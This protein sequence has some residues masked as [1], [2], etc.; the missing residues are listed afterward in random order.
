M[1]TNKERKREV[2]LQSLRQTGSR[3]S[4]TQGNLAPPIFVMRASVVR[5]SKVRKLEK[6]HAFS[7]ERGKVEGWMRAG[8][9]SPASCLGGQKK[10]GNKEKGTRGGEEKSTMGPPVQPSKKAVD[11]TVRRLTPLL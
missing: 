3:E 5:G 4:R 6:I 9:K 7:D 8:G 10:R 2:G 1:Q 11:G